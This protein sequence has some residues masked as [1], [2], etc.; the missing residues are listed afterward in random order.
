[1]VFF[2]LGGTLGSDWIGIVLNCWIVLIVYYFLESFGL[3]GTLVLVSIVL[4]RAAMLGQ[5]CLL[6]LFLGFV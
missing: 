6:I 5:S 2:G 1:M 4:I 3:F